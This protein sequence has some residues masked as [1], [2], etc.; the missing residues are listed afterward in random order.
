MRSLTA[1]LAAAAFAVV[2]AASMVLDGPTELEAA[3][4]VAAEVAALTG[5]GK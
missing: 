2:L 3:E 4:A 1:W 5:G